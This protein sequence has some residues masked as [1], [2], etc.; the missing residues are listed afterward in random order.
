MIE[1][2]LNR[3]ASILRETGSP[4]SVNEIYSR[5]NQELLDSRP[6]LDVLLSLDRRFRRVDPNLWILNAEV[7]SQPILTP[8]KSEGN[9]PSGELAEKV[10]FDRQVAVESLLVQRSNMNDRASS[11][12]MRLQEIQS[13]LIR[14][15]Y[16]QNLIIS[17]RIEKP[18]VI[19]PK[20]IENQADQRYR[21][22]WPLP[23]EQSKLLDTLAVVLREI[24]QN[25][26]H[27]EGLIRWFQKYFGI[28]NW[29]KH[30]ILACLIYPGFAKRMQNQVIPTDLG[31]DYLVSRDPNIIRNAIKKSFWGIEEM[32]VWLN[33]QPMTMDQL[34][35]RF[36]LLGAG[37]EKTA[38]IRYRLNWLI[39][40][41][42]VL[43]EQGHRPVRYMIVRSE[44]R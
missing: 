34:H 10:I 3:V 40:S 16:D 38:Q 26:P 8:Q 12:R 11:I 4:M 6:R 13:L 5:L 37:W 33:E 24:V 36:N 18:S 39:A 1:Q 15:D 44:S 30:S 32:L 14:L 29:A 20:R 25:T 31:L 42:L 27:W 43:E 19:T 21:S 2:I 17:E 7:P 41:G 35:T 28:G 23:G 22:V 9:P